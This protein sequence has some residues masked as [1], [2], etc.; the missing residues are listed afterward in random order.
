MHHSIPSHPTEKKDEG[1]GHHLRIRLGTRGP[2]VGLVICSV[3]VRVVVVVACALESTIT[4]Y[5]DVSAKGI[6]GI[7]D[8]PAQS[9]QCFALKARASIRLLGLGVDLPRFLGLGDEPTWRRRSFG[10]NRDVAMVQWWFVV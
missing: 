4:I 5:Q 6:F 8:N 7:C 3:A 1:K 2:R 10:A 9:G